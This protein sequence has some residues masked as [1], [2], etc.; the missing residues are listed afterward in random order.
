[1]ARRPILRDAIGRLN[2]IEQCG[3]PVDIPSVADNAAIILRKPPR[4]GADMNI[5]EVE[6]GLL[7]N[8]LH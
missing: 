6:S 3:V 5:G 4:R 8:S 7:G 1:L 2:Q